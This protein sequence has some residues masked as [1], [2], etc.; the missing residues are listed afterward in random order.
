MTI[1][2]NYL[3][4]LFEDKKHL[5]TLSIFLCTGLIIAFMKLIIFGLSCFMFS[6]FGLA[7]FIVFGILA[8]FIRTRWVVITTGTVISLLSISIF[9]YA[10]Y[11]LLVIQANAAPLMFIVTPFP[12]AIVTVICFIFL[13][14]IDLIYNKIKNQPNKLKT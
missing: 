5:I 13:F 14:L 10:M 11:S 9:I 3:S 1:T 8:L 7:P 4:T 12:E 2:N 6:V